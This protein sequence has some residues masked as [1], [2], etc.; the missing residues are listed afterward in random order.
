VKQV[1]LKTEVKLQSDIPMQQ[2][3]EI[4][5]ILLLE[6]IGFIYYNLWSTVQEERQ[7]TVLRKTKHIL[8]YHNTGYSADWQFT[9][10]TPAYS[11]TSPTEKRDGY[12]KRNV[13][14]AVVKHTCRTRPVQRHVMLR[15]WRRSRGQT[16]METWHPETQFATPSTGSA[17]RALPF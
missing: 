1:T 9:S 10:Q 8:E 5:Y 11:A 3:A 7:S 15:A 17:V 2:D 12:S 13:L 14:G 6:I 4:Q 16:V